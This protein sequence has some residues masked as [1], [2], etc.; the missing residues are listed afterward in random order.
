MEYTGERLIPKTGL[1]N[2]EEHLLFYQES[3]KHIDSKHFVLDI[4]CGSGWGSQLLANKATNV[5]GMDIDS[6]AVEYAKSNYDAK[7]LNF[8]LGSILNIPF[9]SDT[10]DVVNSIE[11]FEH[12][13][14]DS[15]DTLIN[16]CYRVLKNNGIFILSTPDH[17]V[18]PYHP[19]S[20]EQFRGWHMW[21]YTKK[22]LED[23]LCK[24]FKSVVFNKVIDTHF[25]ICTK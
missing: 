11:T 9:L 4:A 10:F 17:E 6:I 22:E 7:N 19:I 13:G 24:K 15:I 5:V 23:L 2:I 18:F 8:Y 21:H 12:V 3:L 16:E 1:G 14:H 20:P 25:L